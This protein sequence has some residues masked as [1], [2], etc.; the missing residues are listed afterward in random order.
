M[1]APFIFVSEN[2]L[3]QGLPMPKQEIFIILVVASQAGVFTTLWIPAQKIAGMTES[4]GFTK[5]TTDGFVQN[6]SHSFSGK[7]LQE[8]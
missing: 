8:L 5:P 4:K 1:G 7:E 3:R 2:P 6:L